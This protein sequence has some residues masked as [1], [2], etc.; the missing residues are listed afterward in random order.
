M[1][2]LLRNE[3]STVYAAKPSVGAVLVNVHYFTCQGKP[4]DAALLYVFNP[5]TD[6]IITASDKKKKKKKTSTR[7]QNRSL[8]ELALDLHHSGLFVR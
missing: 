7:L 2:L 3:W 8:P 5:G 1:V 4:S 6:G